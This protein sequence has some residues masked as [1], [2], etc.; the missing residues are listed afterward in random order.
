MKKLK[1]LK[2]FKKKPNDTTNKKVKKPLKDKLAVIVSVL[3]VLA[4]LGSTSGIA[5][6]AIIISGAPTLNSSDF[7]ASDSSKLFDSEGNIITD[8]GYQ[9]RENVSY[10]DMPQVLIDA[11]V[12]IEDSRFFEHN[13]FDIPRFTKA[14][15]ENVLS[16]SFSQGGSTFTM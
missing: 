10:D 6:I 9:I 16:M 7:V 12:A 2:A 4:I 1:I 13:G 5:Y 11:F 3:L 14:M 8:V 15:F